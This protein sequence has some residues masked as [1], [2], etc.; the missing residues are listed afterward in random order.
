MKQ[1]I[2]KELITL[3]IILI[4]IT[5][6]YV[7]SERAGI[8]YDLTLSKRHTLD[9]QTIEL[10]REVTVPIKITVIER[11]KTA[12]KKVVIYQPELN[13]ILFEYPRKNPNIMI[14]IIEEKNNPALV[15]EYIQRYGLS[16]GNRAI[17]AQN[18]VTN[19]TAVTYGNTEW[20]F[21]WVIFRVIKRISGADICFIQGHGEKDPYQDKT[22]S[23]YYFLKQ[24][25]EENNYRVKKIYL[26][27]DKASLTGCNVT[28]IAGPKTEYSENEIYI[29]K[30]YFENGGRL[31]ILID[32]YSASLS[33]FLSEYGFII[34]NDTVSDPES[35]F[36]DDYHTLVIREYAVHPTSTGIGATLFPGVRVIGFKKGIRGMLPILL[37]SNKAESKNLHLR[38]KFPVSIVYSPPKT[39]STTKN[40]GRIVLVADSDFVS[41]ELIRFTLKMRFSNLQYFLNV[42]EYLTEEEFKIKILPRQ[43]FE[44]KLKTD[45]NGVILMTEKEF[46]RLLVLSML[47]EPIVILIFAIILI[48]KYKRC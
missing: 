27:R 35:A 13:P 10:L 14:E 7:I 12:G 23:G 28:V 24:I 46:R 4:A 41:N 17:I 40:I 38:G 22:R 8:R 16:G 6:I 11:T 37:T 20:D 1:Y 2:K 42:L 39:N 31:F 43:Y 19:K 45:E 44:A 32:P 30:K 18:L 3:L 47:G 26:G 34:G 15:R 29:L 9:K 33:R 21:D 25:L 36:W 5:L 48:R